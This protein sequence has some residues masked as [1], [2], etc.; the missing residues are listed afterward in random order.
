MLWEYGVN[1]AVFYHNLHLLLLSD[2]ATPAP[3]ISGSSWAINQML[4]VLVGALA[5]GRKPEGDFHLS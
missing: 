5:A 2:P 1:Q 3:L 4:A